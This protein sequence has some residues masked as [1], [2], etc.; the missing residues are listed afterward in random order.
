MKNEPKT[1]PKCKSENITKEGPLDFYSYDMGFI[2]Q[3]YFCEDC[4][5]GFCHE[6]SIKFKK[7]AYLNGQK[8][9]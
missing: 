4:G 8:I 1:C 9:A 6:F 3:Q 2:Y 5:F 7:Q